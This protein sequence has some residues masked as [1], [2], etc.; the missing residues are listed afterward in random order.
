MSDAPEREPEG[1]T[2]H[3]GL[4]RLADSV[5]GL[6]R[7]RVE[8]AAIEYKEERDRVS[9]QLILMVG[10][11]GCLLFALFFAA[12]GVVAAF[13]DTYR[14]AAIIGVTLFFALAGALM[15]WRRQEISNTSPMPFAASV[16]ELEK[17]RAALSR[18]FR[19]PPS[20]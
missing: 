1:G 16:A 5:L 19:T 7:T 14:L 11:A 10:A 8:L 9:R 12:A 6:A 15:L 20:P 17:D 18:T 13:W 2:L 4:L 3:G